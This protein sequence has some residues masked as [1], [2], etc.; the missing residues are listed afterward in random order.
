MPG[1][2]ETG[3]MRGKT[4][5]GKVA[6]LNVDFVDGKMVVTDENG[7][8]HEEFYRLKRRL[9]TEPLRELAKDLS[10]NYGN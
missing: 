5:L 6:Y 1:G 4:K 2:K 3:V 7:Q 10:E 9:E 8:P